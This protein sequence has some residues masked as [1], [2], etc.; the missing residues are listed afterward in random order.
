VAPRAVAATKRALLP[1]A[2]ES[3]LRALLTNCYQRSMLRLILPDSRRS[4]PPLAAGWGS[5]L[6]AR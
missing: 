5:R 4:A 3:M 6:D 2:H 1:G